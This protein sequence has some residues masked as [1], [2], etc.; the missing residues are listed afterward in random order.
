ME[1]FALYFSPSNIRLRTLKLARPRSFMTFETGF[2]SKLD[3]PVNVRDH[4]NFDVF[5]TS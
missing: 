5:R 3:L 1:Q 2:R 4:A